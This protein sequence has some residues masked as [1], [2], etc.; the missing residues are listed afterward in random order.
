MSKQFVQEDLLDWLKIN[1]QLDPQHKK[2]IK[3][4]E[5]LKR[6]PS[7]NDRALEKFQMPGCVPAVC[8]AES[9]SEG[10]GRNGRNWYSPHAQNIDMSL[11]WSFDLPVKNMSALGLAVGVAIAKTLRSN[12]VD[13][14]VKWPNDVLVDGKKIAGILIETRITGTQ[15]INVVIGVGVNFFMDD[16]HVDIDQLWTDVKRSSA[17]DFQLDRNELAAGLLGALIDVCNKYQ[18]HGFAGFKDDWECLDICKNA[19]LELTTEQGFEVGKCM[20][21]DDAGGLIVN[22]DGQSRIFYVADVC[23]RVKA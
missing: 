16:Q 22:I 8:L 2:C 4:F 15:K 10:R 14:G 18:E 20:G 13:A 12:G 11:A 19:V 7:T 17:G 3:D 5:V 23:V 6:V 1:Q 21:I 9:Q